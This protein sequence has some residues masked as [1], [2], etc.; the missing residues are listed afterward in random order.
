MTIEIKDVVA[1]LVA[2]AILLLLTILYAK[3]SPLLSRRDPRFKPILLLAL[4][5]LWFLANWLYL[6]LKLSGFVVFL[7]VSSTFL[8]IAVSRDLYRF[9]S[10]GLLGADPHTRSGLDYTAALTLCRTSLAFLG[11]G[12]SKLTALP[13]PFE[14]ALRR[15][16]HG[17]RPIRFLLCDPNNPS[18][19]RFEKQAGAPQ[20]DYRR[21]IEDSL[22]V[23]ADLKNRLA[24]NIEVKLYDDQTMPLFRLMFIDDMVCLASHYRF[25]A[26][27]GS[28]LPQ[29]HVRRA[30]TG[31]PEASS[32][33]YVFEEYFDRLWRQSREWDFRL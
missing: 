17:H 24:M 30:S 22:H 5:L 32:F 31:S 26:G 23:L 8:A 14:D 28:D 18:L 19:S 7:A 33:Y 10:V 13:Q 12:A 25:G 6:Q 2:D 21:R 27:D 9:W 11:V 15:C 3:L 20:G 16:S 4:W 29:L 1:N